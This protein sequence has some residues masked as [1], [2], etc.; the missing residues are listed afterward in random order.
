MLFGK[1][2]TTIGV[3]AA[4]LGG[5]AMGAEGAFVGYVV[6][7]TPL[8]HTGAGAQ[9]AFIAYT[10]Y[11]RFNGATD[12]VL[13]AFNLGLVG[14]GPLTGFYHKDN[15]SYNTSTMM[16]E[17]GTWNPS[18]TGA[19]ANRAY[20]SYLV[21][22]GLPT[23]TNTT[24]A[25]PT[26]TSGG[27]ADARSWNRPDLPNNG[28]IGW[29]NSNPT[30]L[31]GRVGN[32]P[33]L[34][35]TDVR[36][37]QFVVSAS[38]TS[39]RV[40]QL[41]IGY[42]SGIAGAPV[43]FGIG[44]F[45][46]GS[47]P[48]PNLYRDLD[49]DGF[50]SASNGTVVSCVPVAGYVANNTDCNDANPAINPNTVWFRDLDGD[51]FGF[52][53]DGTL[54]Q[55]A[56]PAGYAIIGNDNCPSISNPTQADCN[57]NGIGDTCELAS[58]LVLDCDGDG[59]PD[60]CEGAVVVDT[61]SPVFAPF[62]NGFPA[63][64]TFA[65]LPKA[66]GPNPTLTVEVTSD[67]NLASEYI[68]V[69]FDGG[70]QEFYFVANGSDC[71]NDSFTRTFTVAE[72][73]QLVADGNL[74][75]R[76]VASGTVD[77]LQ[78]PNSRLRMSLL[79]AGLPASSDCNGNGLLDTCEI[80]T[81]A[82]FDCDGNGLIDTCDVAAGYGTDCNGN[83]KLDSCDLAT[84]PST[85]LDGNGVPDECA[86]EFV[87]G[88]SGYGT[89]AAAVDA[90]PAGTTIRV[91]PG[92]Y[93]E[94]ITVT[95]ALTLRSLGGP[96]A[97]VLSGSG[98]AAGS[99]VAVRS[100]AASGTVIEGFTLTQGTVGTA[101]FGARF[102]G[103]VYLEDTQATVRNCRL[104]AN[105]ADNGGALYAYAS[106]ATVEQCVFESNS[107][108]DEGGAACFAAGGS[109]TFTGNTLAANSA[110]THGGAVSVDDAAGTLAQSD[111]S[112]NSAGGQGGA[113]AWRSSAA[114]PAL[115][116]TGC[117]FGGNTGSNAAVARIGAPLPFEI[118]GSRFC[119]NTPSNLSGAYTD[120]GGNLFS[121]DCNSNGI[122]DADEISSGAEG[123]C[124]ANGLPDSCEFGRTVAWG[125]NSTGQT[126]VPADVGPA[127]AVSAGCNH[128]LALRADGSVAA[129]GSNSFG[130]LGLGG[131]TS[132][133]AIAAGCDH[134]LALRADGTV[135]AVGYNAFGQTNVPGSLAGVVQVAAGA[136]HSGARLADGSLVL[137]GRNVDG[138]CN[139][140]AGLGVTNQ[141][142]L[143]GAHSMALRGDGT[144]ACW[145]LNNF[146]QCTVPAGVGSLVSVAAGCYHSVGLRTDGTVR[147]WGSSLFGQTTVPAG[148]ADVVE[149]AA[150]SGQH[151]IA[152]KSD[153]SVVAWGW[154][155]FG[156]TTAPAALGR[157]G[158]I[159]AG[160]TFTLVQIE[161]AR[162]CN[163]NGVLDSC[164]IASGAAP[165]CNTN[166]IPDSCDIATGKSNDC[167]GNG[168]P[169]NC[170]LA[171]GA[172][173]DCNGNLV[174]DSCDIASGASSDL[175]NNQVPDECSGEFVV[176]G[177][178][179]ASVQAA[180]DA[181]PSGTQILVAVAADAGP[182]VIE[183]KAVSLVPLGALNTQLTGGGAGSIIT[184][185]GAAA[186]GS[187]I[188]AFA[189][190]GGVSGT[191]VDGVRVGGAI[192]VIDA[193]NISIAGSTF[194]G[195]SADLG[196]AIYA[197][198][199]GLAISGCGFEGNSA[200]ADGGALHLDG[201]S[202]SCTGCIFTANS[203]SGAGGAIAWVAAG[204]AGFVL[205]GCAIEAN[206][207]LSG[208]GISV[209]P[210]GAAD[211]SAAAIDLVRTRLCRNAPDNIAGAFN[212][213][214]ENTFSEDCNGNGICDAD[215]IAGGSEPDCNG[216]GVLD[217]CE[218]TGTV[219]GFG[220]DT[221]GQLAVPSGIG[222]I[223]DI[224][225]GCDHTVAQLADGTLRAWGLNGSGAATVP[226]SLGPVTLFAAGCDHNLAVNAAG[227]VV[228]WGGNSYGQS[229][230]PPSANGAVAQVA[231]GAFFSGVRRNDGSVVLWGRNAEGQCNAPLA[232]AGSAQLALGGAHAMSLRAD[233]SVV[234]WGLNNFGQCDVPA[235]VGTLRAI[236]A[237]CYH[238][239][240]LRTDGTVVCWGSNL[241]G[242]T[243]VPAGLGG[244]VAVAA[245][246]GQHTLA[247]RSDGSVVAWGWNN[248]GQSSVPPT[249]REIGRIAAGGAHSL[250]LTRIAP[251]CNGNGALDSCDIAGGAATDCNGNAIP[252]SCDLASGLATDCNG[253]GTLDSC[254][255]ASGTPDCNGNA[256]PDSCDLAA[257]LSSDL[258]GNGV[259]DEC[260]GE[261]IVG[262]TGFASIQA[263]VDA[264]TDGA[265]IRVSAGTWPPFAITGKRLSIAPLGANG[266]VTVDGG[267]T[268]RCIAMTDV[269][270][271]AVVVRGIVVANGSAVDGG[272]VRLLR[273]SPLFV[274]CVFTDNT[275]SQSGGAVRCQSSAPYF[276]RCAFT[277]N[278]ANNGGAISLVGVAPT[279]T[280]AM[281]AGCELT[282]N[283][284][285]GDGGALHN[286]TQ[287]Q[288][289]GCRVLG[290]GSG[291]FGG[292]LFTGTS[293]ISRVGNSYFCLNAPNNATG[294][295]EDFGGNFMGAD[296]NNNGICDD[297]DILSGVAEDKNGNRK[298]DSCE[299]AFGD[300]DLSGTVDGGDLSV[301]LN[302]WGAINPP[303]G[304]MNGDGIIQG[305]DL[306]ILLG[307]WGLSP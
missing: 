201:A 99:I 204:S 268:A 19:I 228:A 78:C 42:N 101:A 294:F 199:S 186:S 122:C 260:P 40:F 91:A 31:A 256:A 284:A 191:D 107:A 304:D 230:V 83:G 175:N 148:L 69:S 60:I 13:N 247:L 184:I 92:T 23:G 120:L 112:N 272:G 98:L 275:A 12:T 114:S 52:A 105:H 59:T 281:L 129:W 165:D 135:M 187:S 243:S 117:A 238:S 282:S 227:A 307:N 93:A 55:C 259:P 212:D 141:L 262:G 210:S 235:S 193:D 188:G 29:F 27:N 63:D 258:D 285:N 271:N 84:G 183:G 266:S 142:A 30:N 75:V 172:V 276:D 37:G 269:E 197:R 24:N 82:A 47:T 139:V 167:D 132:V 1:T 254:D 41:E 290:N 155:A 278:T 17:F 21:I 211:P 74:Q 15:A 97:T 189:F 289:D 295:V 207:A 291:G 94:A 181:A 87:V 58:G 169:D 66:Y 261:F 70:T 149:V 218:L 16:S 7:A 299:I 200:S 33:G 250:L 150:G 102:G 45:Q 163:A 3:G 246:A 145:G 164:D 229:T 257:G 152:L 223:V 25:D 138:E 301:I 166:G 225:A 131:M 190:T 143:G 28:T 252:D 298:I 77:A 9:G 264:A 240:G 203:A 274:E 273:A 86:G 26:W 239:V 34:P 49:G 214:G 286:L 173:P 244:V 220:S 6:V 133:A 306:T 205:D 221:F 176:G 245:G 140:P 300:F 8:N 109:F 106:A 157:V 20:D 118:G 277:G 89:I 126:D 170:D 121:Q 71:G 96:D 234:C 206:A 115:R 116:I 43:Q 213:L 11:A 57:A 123:D 156:Q 242:Q 61:D 219:I 303:T 292:G 22:G 44:T 95:K 151:T 136:N 104:I 305:A 125:E 241:F 209:D 46:L 73:N 54:V 146:G 85:D 283:V 297:D 224:A 50:G 182:I 177:T 72:F 62:G 160:G 38:D 287:L 2:L 130:Q 178:G 255:L 64:F 108:K 100:A 302:F 179:F 265:A 4:V 280:F 171:A 270:P 196:G 154:N 217:S 88:G 18:Q 233:G 251:D 194:T 90:A 279:G 215:E 32:S 248:F 185:R 5:A 36:I 10:V 296:C 35:T 113:L 236:A 65:S 127:L 147:C 202:G 288:L 195:C 81:G 76:I 68:G 56:Q 53:S 14:G 158:L 208:G 293:G 124:N 180:I 263:A 144:V 48:C 134:S 153:G 137:W 159:A 237:G 110:G 198:G 67:L 79:Y 111:F 216:N 267:G 253:N 128:A 51:G 80:G 119:L 174:P 161:A 39:A 232:A 249:T 168:V 226:P 192:A 222:E 103:A 231:A 162:D